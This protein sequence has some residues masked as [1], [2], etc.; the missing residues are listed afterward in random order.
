ME[1]SLSSLLEHQEHE[2]GAPPS[3]AQIPHRKAGGPLWPPFVLRAVALSGASRHDVHR[4]IFVLFRS[5]LRGHSASPMESLLPHQGRSSN[6]A[7]AYSS[8]SAW[9]GDA[10]GTPEHPYSAIAAAAY[11]ARTKT[12]DKRYTTDQDYSR[13]TDLV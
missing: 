6:K 10:A 13:K 7:A 12:W 5:C 11:V 8:R 2:A 9:G 3:V 1:G 4:R